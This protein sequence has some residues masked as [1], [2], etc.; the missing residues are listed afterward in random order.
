MTDAQDPLAIV[1]DLHLQNALNSTVRSGEGAIEASS[2]SGLD[3]DAGDDAHSYWYSYARSTPVPGGAMNGNHFEQG[4]QV[5]QG[6]VAVSTHQVVTD[7]FDMTSPNAS[8][9]AALEYRVDGTGA[10]LW[11]SAGVSGECNLTSLC[12]PEVWV[13]DFD[14]DGVTDDADNC[15]F[16]SNPDQADQN[17]DGIGDACAKS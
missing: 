10:P 9:A 4:F 17:D 1:V 7:E 16:V 8:L 12:P 13:N 3:F 15:P 14:H 2:W 6:A 5:G 11:G